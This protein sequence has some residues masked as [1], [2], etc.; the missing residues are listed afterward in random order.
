M[1]SIEVVPWSKNANANALAKLIRDAELLDAI[2]VEFL[3]EPS[4]KQRP[5]VMELE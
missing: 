5:E 2:S 1:V 3:A 4:I